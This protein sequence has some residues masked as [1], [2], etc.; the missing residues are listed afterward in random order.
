[1]LSSSTPFKIHGDENVLSSRKQLGGT[2]T[3]KKHFGGKDGLSKTPMVPKSSRK[4]LGSISI[5]KKVDHEGATFGGGKGGD[6]ISSSSSR[7]NFNVLKS[8]KKVNSGPSLD[9]AGMVCSHV[10]H[11]LDA[12][13]A[14]INAASKMKTVVVPATAVEM[15]C[16]FTSGEEAADEN[17][18][19]S[20]ADMDSCALSLGGCTDDTGGYSFAPDTSE[21]IW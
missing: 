5:N 17:F 6:Q 2:T 13:D 1:M 10:T 21:E 12:Y 8:S 20:S 19:A 4:A 15:K 9:A 3:S 16:P 7:L 11:D 18:W 14:T